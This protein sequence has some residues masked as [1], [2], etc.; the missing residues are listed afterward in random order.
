VAISHHVA[1]DLRIDAVF[2]TR[3]LGGQRGFDFEPHDRG[4]RKHHFFELPYRWS[5]RFS[6]PHGFLNRFGPWRW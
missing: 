3:P 2:H 5:G 6:R 1:R 4:G